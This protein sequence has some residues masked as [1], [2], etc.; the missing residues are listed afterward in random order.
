MSW[1]FVMSANET[2][3][4]NLRMKNR[5]LNGFFENKRGICI[6]LYYDEFAVLFIEGTNKV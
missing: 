1:H 4:K 5:Q 2:A 3:G 6:S